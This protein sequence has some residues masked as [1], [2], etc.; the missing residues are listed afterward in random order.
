MDAAAPADTM[1]LHFPFQLEFLTSISLS[2]HHCN[3][4]PFEMDSTI[5]HLGQPNIWANI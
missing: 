1:F 3:K 5:K 4:S 2:S